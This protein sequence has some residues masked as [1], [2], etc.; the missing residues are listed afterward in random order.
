MQPDRTALLDPPAARAHPGA[1]RR[2][3]HDDP[4][5]QARA[6]P[7]FVAASTVTSTTSRATTTCSALTRP[8]IVATI[9]D[10]Y[11]E[12]GA[13]IIETN[14]FN[15]TGI[16]QADY[17]MAGRVREMNRAAA[18]H[19]ARMRRRLDRAH[20][21]PAALRRRRAGPDQPHRVDLARRQRSRRAQRQLRRAGRGLRRGR[22]GPGRGRRRHPARRD[23]LRH[24]ERQGRAVRDRGALRAPGPA[25][26]ADRLRHDHR[27]LRPHAVRA[28]A[29]GVLELGA[30]R[31]AARGRPRTAR[32]G[33]ALMRPYIEEIARVADTF[34]IC[35]PNAGLPNPMSDTGYDETPE[36]TSAAARRLRAE[37]LRRTSSAAAAAPRPRTSAPSPRRCVAAAA[38]G[39]ACRNWRRRPRRFRRMAARHSSPRCAH[40]APAHRRARCCIDPS[41][42][43]AH[44]THHAPRRPRTAQHRRRLAVR[45]RRRAHQRHRLARVRAA[46]PRRRLRRRGRGR[47]PAGGE[48]RADHRR[49]HGRG[50]ARLEGGDGALPE[51]DRRRTR[52]RPRAGDDRLV[53]VGGD[54]GGPEM[55]AGQ[56]DRQL[57]LAQGGRRGVP[58]PG[59]AGA[60]LRRRGRSSW[61]ST[62]RARPTASSA[63][64]RSAAAATTCWSTGSAFRPR[65]SSS[66]RTS[67]PSPPASR[68]TTTTRSTSSRRRA[69]SGEHL[70]HA[71]VSGGISNVSFSF[72]GNDAG[73]RGDPHRV[74][75][76]RDPR[77]PDDGHRQRRSARRLRRTRSRTARACRGR[78][79]QSPARRDRAAG[80]PSPRRSRRRAGRSSRTWPG[81][82]AAWR[83]A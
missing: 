17:G 64:P 2:D 72:R 43:T 31:A 4:A 28:D 22:G 59:D 3:G 55:R 60:P 15:A 33:A 21:R 23:H 54:R 25:A 18:R 73:A 66:T 46:D 45:Q 48:R 79:A 70:P 29:R 42:T 57:D 11:L 39:A 53:E 24:A 14:T 44:V 75:L 5:A 1:R 82:A 12:A 41:R 83:S 9:H 80:R 69:G 77:R 81:A 50:D 34:V 74:P 52:H 56:A 76:P 36:Q 68:S 40:A 51:P 63:R 30:P 8:E 78:G 49:Q 35:Y 38:R 6:R 27:R 13:D 32:S 10:E 20:A 7:S 62:R 47:A 26:A 65:T 16:A 19:R 37:R 58:A 71:K 61:P 67:S